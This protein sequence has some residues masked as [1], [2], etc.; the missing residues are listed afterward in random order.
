VKHWQIALAIF[1]SLSVSLA[2]ADDFKTINGKEYKNATV[3][4]VEAD[5]IVLK[6]KSGV[7]KVYFNELPEDLQRRFHNVEADKSPAKAGRGAP[8]GA[9]HRK[10]DRRCDDLCGRPASLPK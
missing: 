10:L 9:A 1:A 8:N 3:N 6:T 4:R 7:S 5:G 2:L